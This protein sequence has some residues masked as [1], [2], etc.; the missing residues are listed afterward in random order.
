MA[1]DAPTPKEMLRFDARKALHGQVIVV[2]H[3][4]AAVNA[5]SLLM[6]VTSSSRERQLAVA[7]PARA[8]SYSSC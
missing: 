7:R 1:D 4:D 8:A 3:R 2:D 6:W 5:A